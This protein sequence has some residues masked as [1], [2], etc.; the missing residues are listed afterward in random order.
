[1]TQFKYKKAQK[2]CQ[3]SDPFA[4]AET[5]GNHR[6]KH[7]IE[8]ADGVKQK[9]RHEGGAA[10]GEGEK[11]NEILRKGQQGHLKT[12]SRKQRKI[13]QR[14]RKV[15]GAIVSC[16]KLPPPPKGRKT[17]IKG[18]A[19]KKKIL[20]QGFQSPRRTGPAHP[21]GKSRTGTCG[22]HDVEQPSREGQTT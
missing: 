2:V 6:L 3:T 22:G 1:L 14:S 4:C 5:F 16:V 12:F 21:S 9:N 19:D 11:K 17:D 13:R 18:K 7:V 20:V 15:D 10:N 8:I